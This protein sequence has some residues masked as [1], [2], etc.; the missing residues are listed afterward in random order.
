MNFRLNK[1]KKLRPCDAFWWFSGFITWGI[2]GLKAA[3]VPQKKILAVES[4]AAG[5]ALLERGRDKAR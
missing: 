2:K 4:S 5:G 1:Y 3:A